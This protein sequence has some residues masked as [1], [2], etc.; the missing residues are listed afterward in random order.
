MFWLKLK[1]AAAW[2]R[3]HWR[4]LILSIA[5]AVVYTLGRKGHK[6]LKLQAELARKQYLRE[7]EAIQ[8]AHDTEIRMREEA[9]KRYSDAVSKIEERYEKD[10]WNMTQSKKEQIKSLLREAKE[11]PDEVDRILEQELG[12]KKQ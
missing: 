2:C 3:Q 6:N 5:F 12:I 7:K 10:K 1:I 4:W 8:R 9:E 11:N